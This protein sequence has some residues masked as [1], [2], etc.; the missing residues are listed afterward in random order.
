MKVK[1]IIL[2]F[3][4]SLAAVVGIMMNASKAQPKSVQ[5]QIT[6]LEEKE[7]AAGLTLQ[8]RVGLAKLRG[9]RK[10]VIPKSYGTSFYAGFK[11]LETAA[12]VYSIVIAQPVAMINRTTDD[13]RVVTS[14]KFKTLEVLSEPVSP[15]SPFT[16]HGSL[17]AEF[18][19][20]DNDEFL[21]TT[22][23]GTMNIDGVEVATKYDDFEPFALA[24]KYLL[25][26]NF[27]SSKKVGGL[28]MGP[29]SALVVGDEGS[30]RTLDNQ[31]HHAVKRA[32][33]AKFG[34]SIER[35]K[36]YLKSKV[37]PH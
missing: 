37:R 12:A 25:F 33:D 18:Q 22:L 2:C 3:L 9:E 21:L 17:P 36:D 15:P 10:V 20:F 11:D 7:K 32:V 34:N 19:P 8:E 23:G 26:L 6:E 28:G 31:P 14:Y 29:L 27:D 30:M 24:N 1:I 35:L 13:G 16:F 5:Q 4:I